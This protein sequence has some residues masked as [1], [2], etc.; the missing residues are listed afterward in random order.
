M[1]S[2]ERRRLRTLA[3]P[4]DGN[5]VPVALRR[6]VEADWLEDGPDEWV[7][8]SLRAH[9]RWSDARRAW[10]T[11]NG[12]DL[13]ARYGEKPGRDWWAFA[14]LCKGEGSGPP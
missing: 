14:A 13:H 1:T 8:R 9:R 2:S 10:A 7:E 6:Y 11:L 3:P 12:Y 4:D 5:P